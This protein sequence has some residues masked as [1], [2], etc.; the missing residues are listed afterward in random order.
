MTETNEQATDPTQPGY[1]ARRGVT[2]ANEQQMRAD[3][4]R[5]EQLLEEA[6]HAGDLREYVKIAEPAEEIHRKWA[7]HESATAQA[8]WAYLS[9]VREDWRREPGSMERLY[10]QV[11]IDRV[12]GV[13]MGMSP[14]EWRSLR[15]AREMAGHGDWPQARDPYSVESLQARPTSAADP[16]SLNHYVDSAESWN[17]SLMR[18]DFA[19]VYQLGEQRGRTY[20]DSEYLQLTE[21]MHDIAEP[22]AFR[23]DALG[24]AWRDMSTLAE[25]SYS[26]SEYDYAVERIEQ[27]LP[28]NDD[29]RARMFGRSTDQIQELK[30]IARSYFSHDASRTPPQVASTAFAATR[31][32]EL[33]QRG[34]RPI[35]GHA[36]A[37]LVGGREQEGLER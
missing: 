20:T 19:Q 36:F 37:G 11:I 29:A 16:A 12:H 26:D 15:Q 27:R 5:A 2:S 23:D 21:Q 35:P 10:E 28:E 3:A 34:R 30:G 1:Y 31:T 33:R 14:A 24:L 17:E 25:A 4:V 7:N 32:T 9:D 8:D 13:A 22:W 18:A 6:R